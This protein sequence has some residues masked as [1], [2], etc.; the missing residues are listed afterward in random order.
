MLRSLLI[1]KQ[2]LRQEGGRVP[3][4][5]EVDMAD[6]RD[7]VTA[8][9]ARDLEGQGIKTGFTRKRLKNDYEI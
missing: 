2:D 3:N 5:L 1:R 7:Y 6:I 8:I 4:S 9:H